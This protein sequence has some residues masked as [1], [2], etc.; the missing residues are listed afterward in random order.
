MRVEHLCCM[1]MCLAKC[2]DF[3]PTLCI[4]LLKQV[5]EGT[6][7][8]AQYEGDISWHVHTSSIK[9]ELSPPPS[10]ILWNVNKIKM[11]CLDARINQKVVTWAILGP[12]ILQKTLRA[13]LERRER[14]VSRVLIL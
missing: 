2:K 9:Y 8:P 5:T 3:Q 13:I 14:S 4:L 12:L 10:M 1:K 7:P 11:R 6:W